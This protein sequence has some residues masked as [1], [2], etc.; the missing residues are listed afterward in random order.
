MFLEDFS[1]VLSATK[2]HTHDAKPVE[3]FREEEHDNKKDS[4]DSDLEISSDSDT[5]EEL[6]QQPIKI[7]ELG[8]K[9]ECL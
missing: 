6:N 8:M 4:L 7:L 9:G 3:V 2:K 1:K 5:E